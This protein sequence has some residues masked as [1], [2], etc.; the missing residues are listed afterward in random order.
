MRTGSEAI[1]P[2]RAA[3]WEIDLSE[4]ARSSPERLRAG[5]KRMFIALPSCRGDREAQVRDQSLGAS[6]VLVTGDP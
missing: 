1:P 2:S 3:R 4:G 6:G 5:S